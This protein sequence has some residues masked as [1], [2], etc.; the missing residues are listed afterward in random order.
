MVPSPPSEPEKNQDENEPELDD[1]MSELLADFEA[2]SDANDPKAQEEAALRAF[3]KIMERDHEPSPWLIAMTAAHEREAVADWEGAEKAYKVALETEP[4]KPSSQAMVWEKLSSLYSMTGRDDMAF[5]AT[6]TAT[7]LERSAA[8]PMLL[9]LRLA[10]EAAFYLKWGDWQ[11]ALELIEEGLA[12][13]DEEIKNSIY[14]AQLLPTRARCLVLKGDLDAA[15]AD[16]DTVWKLVEPHDEGYIF[17]GWQG[18][19]ANYWNV[20][21]Q[22]RASRGDLPGVVEAHREVV[23]RR[24]IIAELPQLEG[25]YKHN[26][27]GRALYDLAQALHNVGDPEADEL[28]EESR[29]LRRSIGLDEIDV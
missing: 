8:H 6:Q 25:P 14:H 7:R 23:Y 9:H 3:E 1:E 28:F 27:L 4:H 26:A 2:A 21:A 11:K 19:L 10:H 29:S 18:A 24:R 22:L 13:A 16:L 17:A 15:Q 12:W 20:T 5:E